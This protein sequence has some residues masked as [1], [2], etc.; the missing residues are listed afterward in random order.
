[1]ASGVLHVYGSVVIMRKMSPIG[2]PIRSA[3]R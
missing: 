2:M 3:L 1:M